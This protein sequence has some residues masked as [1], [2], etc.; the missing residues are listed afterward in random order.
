MVEKEKQPEKEGQFNGLFRAF[1]KVNP[2]ITP[3]Q[4]SHVKILG[5]SAV[6]V[7]VL[8]WLLLVMSRSCGL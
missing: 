8:G 5:A 3:Q 7:A 4:K 1:D 2:D 6:V